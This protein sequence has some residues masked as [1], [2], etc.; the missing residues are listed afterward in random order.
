MSVKRDALKERIVFYKDMIKLYAYFFYLSVAIAGWFADKF[1]FS[2]G[3]KENASLLEV[4]VFAISLIFVFMSFVTALIFR[5][6]TERLIDKL[7]VMEEE[8]I[9]KGK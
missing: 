9:K 5:N 8:E 3:N 7:E 1:L 6:K 2:K 4:A